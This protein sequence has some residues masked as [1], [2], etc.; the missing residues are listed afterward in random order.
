MR[1]SDRAN[2][3]A[4][5]TRSFLVGPRVHLTAPPITLAF[6]SGE[7]AALQDVP[8]TFP[9]A[10]SLRYPILL[11]LE[12]VL[13]NWT[14]S[15]PMTMIKYVRYQLQKRADSFS[16]LS[17]PSRLRQEFIVDMAA[18]VSR[19]STEAR[20]TE[21]ETT[22]IPTWSTQIL[23]NQYRFYTFD[24]RVNRM[25]LPPD[26]V[27]GDHHTWVVGATD[28]ISDTQ[29]AVLPRDFQGGAPWAQDKRSDAHRL[30][31]R[32]GGPH[33]FVTFTA[34]PNWAELDVAGQGPAED[35]AD[36]L[37]RVFKVSYTCGAGQRMLMVLTLV[38]LLRGPDQT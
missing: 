26:Q 7:S 37:V 2:F 25:A 11:A 15:S 4:P 21:D 28:L 29:Q 27:N 3:W 38:C 22:D 17:V 31:Q 14:P 19:A 13:P 18:Q 1:T 16:S 20:V 35:R 32:V 34:N 23:R 6:P 12:A 9:L 24:H 10:W 33:L 8:S 5:L 36:T 30:F